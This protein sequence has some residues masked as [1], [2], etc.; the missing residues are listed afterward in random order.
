MEV[1]DECGAWAPE[2]AKACGSCGAS[3]LERVRGAQGDPRCVQVR[4]EFTCRGCA[5]AAPLDRL[6]DD[7]IVTCCRCGLRQGL[8]T[9]DLRAVLQTAWGVADL[10]HP[11]PEGDRPGPIS[12]AA[13][14]P[15]RNP[16][17]PGKRFDS[18]LPEML[19]AWLGRG[20]PLDDAERSPMLVTVEERGH[21]VTSTGARYAVSPGALALCPGLLGVVA[22]E[23]R[24][25]E[26]SVE[27]A[28]AAEGEAF[29]CA[30]CGA[31]LP[32]DGTVRLVRC[33]YCDAVHHVASDLRHRL[34]DDP[35]P[36]VWWLVF[37]GPSPLRRQ[38]ESDP[39]RP[40]TVQSLADAEL[41]AGRKTVDMAM[42]LGIPT[43][44]LVL[45]GVVVETGLFVLHLAGLR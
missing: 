42:A 29:A 43:A 8:D 5:L 41:G 10:Y 30:R 15:Y 36:D 4:L 23:H 11:D 33:T 25:D 22:D 24:V 35:L 45:A 31:A 16:E 28:H 32:V 2:G 34:R 38:L 9:D 20:I 40:R 12:V 1:C 3:P 39:P 6:A 7:G 13:I 17:Q 27:L 18:E 37:E 19:A 26:S 44:A 21:V 14:N